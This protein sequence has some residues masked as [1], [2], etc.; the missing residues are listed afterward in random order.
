MLG[1]K[2]KRGQKS[3]WG[4]WVVSTGIKEDQ[5]VKNG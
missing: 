1:K 5:M 3:R 2:R 4:Y